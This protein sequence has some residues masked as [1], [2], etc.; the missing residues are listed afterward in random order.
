MFSKKRT[1]GSSWGS[2]WLTKRGYFLNDGLSLFSYSA[3]SNPDSSNTFDVNKQPRGLIAPILTYNSKNPC[4]RRFAI[5][6]SHQGHS[7]DDF[8]LSELSQIILKLFTDFSL[9]ETSLDEKR[10]QFCPLHDEPMVCFENGFDTTLQS[11]IQR[12]NTFVKT[13]NC[14]FHS[15]DLVMKKDH[16]VYGKSDSARSQDSMVIFN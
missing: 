13:D 11:Q 3:D 8:A 12:V 10:L 4:I 6:Y 14:S 1:L 16:N 15:I 7:E 5:A 2:K 9:Y